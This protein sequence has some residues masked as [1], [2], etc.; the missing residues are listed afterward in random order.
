[1]RTA[2][3]KALPKKTISIVLPDL[4]GG[5]A[6]R[7]NLD[8]AKGF[9]QRGFNVEFVL[10]NARGPLM[11]DAE[12]LGSIVDLKSPRVRSVISPLTSYIA[13]RRPDALLASMWP[14]T[15][16]AIWARARSRHR[17]SAVL[18]EHGILSRQYENRGALHS[19][20]LRQ[21]L[22]YAA[23]RAEGV[24]GV[25]KGVVEDLATLTGCDRDQF[26]VI[27]NPV[28]GETAPN[29]QMR[30]N[31]EALW[32]G[33]AGKRIIS[34]GTFKPVK[35]QVLLIDALALLD[36][37]EARL[38]LVGDGELRRDLERH[39]KG[40]GVADR[41]KFPG[42]QTDLS[43]FYASAD[44]F[45]LA[46]WREGFGN[47]IVEAMNHG[48]KVVSTDCPTG[49]REILDDGKF[50]R[51]TQPGD[52]EQMAT[53]LAEML[54]TPPDTERQKSR[55]FQFRPD[56]AIDAYLDLLLP[57]NGNTVDE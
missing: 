32:D 26:E 17:C 1:M 45:A 9:T 23:Q 44:V 37:P 15:A 27:Y 47:V 18:V 11:E 50:G 8:L 14:L 41:V 49:P 30:A 42:F 19:M 39:A 40:R 29:H 2:L 13:E 25:S 4:R 56:V 22:R 3:G 6:E 36:D 46:S 16:I 54:T 57:D 31:V 52:V 7:V 55:A 12:T 34:V 35:N 43:A 20:A 33:G 5:G 24:V 21:S 38:M 48:L 10:R 53:A 51:L 28:P